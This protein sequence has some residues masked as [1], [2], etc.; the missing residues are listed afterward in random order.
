VIFKYNN[1]ENEQEAIIGN[2]AFK[3]LGENPQF[4]TLNSKFAEKVGAELDSL[5]IKW[6]G[7]V[8]GER[9]LIAV[10][11]DDS[12]S[13]ESAVET[14]KTKSKTEGQSASEVSPQASEKLQ[15][16]IARTPEVQNSQSTENM[17]NMETPT[18]RKGGRK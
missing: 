16:A 2:T 1:R 7:K 17:E 14:A 4:K 8:D 3:E 10:A 13:L 11:S 5:G 9:T 6:S 15:N 12:D 18:P